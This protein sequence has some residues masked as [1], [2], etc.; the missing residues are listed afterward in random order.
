MPLIH[1]TL[2]HNLE[3]L[4]ADLESGKLGLVVH[5]VE[6]PGKSEIVQLLMTA[7]QRLRDRR[8]QL[9]AVRDALSDDH[10]LWE[11]EGDQ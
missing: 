5:K 11:K 1:E 10:G 4:A 6:Y 8:A 2:D 7:A 3:Q 9:E